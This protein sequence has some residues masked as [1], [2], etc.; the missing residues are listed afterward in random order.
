MT[1]GG[2]GQGE[3]NLC[4][5][6][7]LAVEGDLAG[8]GLDQGLGDGEA[9]AVV[10]GFLAVQ[11]SEMFEDVGQVLRRDAGAVVDDESGSGGHRWADRHHAGRGETEAL[12]SRMSSIWRSA[13][14][15]PTPGLGQPEDSAWLGGYGLAAPSSIRQANRPPG[16]R[17]A[18]G[19]IR[20]ESRS[21]SSTRRSM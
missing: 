12:S 8:L 14:G 3:D 5:T 10:A 15:R 1:S 18:G 13:A 19:G 9:Q 16:A 17:P 4:A 20:R 21:R 2:G 11:D 6:A 7:R